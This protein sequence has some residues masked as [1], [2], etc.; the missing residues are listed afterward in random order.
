MDYSVFDYL[1]NPILATDQKGEIKY[2]NHVCSIF[3]KLPPRKLSNIKKIEDLLIAN[4]F[5]LL[6][7]IKRAHKDQSPVVSPEI[8]IK[9]ADLNF[10]VILKFIPFDKSVVIHLQDFSIERQLHEKYKEQILELKS[11]H[12]QIL[13]SDKLTAMGELIAGVSH[14]ISS[15]LTIANDTLLALSDHLQKNDV[16]KA[17]IDLSELEDEFTRIKQIVS[18]MQAMARNK[19]DSVELVDLNQAIK[20]AIKYSEELGILKNIKVTTNFP[21][22]SLV[23]ANNG[24]LQ[25]VFLNMIKNSSDALKNTKDKEIIF[26]VTQNDQGLVIDIKDNGEGVEDPEKIFE[27]FFTTKELGE[28]TGLGLAISQ[29]IINSFNGSIRNLEA[30]IGAHFKIEFP[31]IDVESFTRTNR[32]LKGEC[33]LEDLKVAIVCEDLKVLNTI[34]NHFNGKNIILVLIDNV[35]EA[36]NIV[37]A[38]MADYLVNFVTG[39]D[40]SF[41]SSTY[42]DVSKL[43]L[44]KQIAKI[45]ELVNG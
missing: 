34:F 23:M 43:S 35:D 45:Q 29:K 24:K 38:Y 9:V 10:T 40:L 5:D 39:K 3:F 4:D 44:D 42:Y 25:Q 8:R 41:I 16:S 37:D 6:S 26:K 13:K 21:K 7:D 33:E 28:G 11:T 12:E 1:Q 31:S 14:E 18:N 22:Q 2:F 30:K 36:E 32:Y 15:P 17:K 27:M 20:E 19:E